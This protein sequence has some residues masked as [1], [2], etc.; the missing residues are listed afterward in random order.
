FQDDYRILPSLNLNLGL[1]WDSFE[2]AHDLL[3][4]TT[5]FDPTLAP[6]GGNPFLFA[7]DSTL[8]GIVGS[9]GVGPCGSKECRDNNNFGPRVGFSWDPFRN[10][11][12]VVRGGYGIYFQRLSNQNFLQGSLGP[13][14][15]VQLAIQNP[16]GVT[17]ANPLPNQPAG[18]AVDPTRIPSG[19]RFAGVSGTGDPNNPNNVPIFVNSAGQACQGFG[20][21]ATNCSINLA[22]FSSVPPDA[23]A[24]YNQQWNF[25]I[26]R[27]LGHSW[28]VELGYRGA[29][30][31][32]G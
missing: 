31:V 9:K 1:R 15:F 23:H 30:Y 3:F 17:L 21:T 10:H 28:A 26:Q 22:S 5:I 8:P 13:P 24:P 27:E 25:T 32:R 19:S 6:N 20:G 14:F 11:R 4:R 2:F 12:T 18:S 7:E 29:H 16:S